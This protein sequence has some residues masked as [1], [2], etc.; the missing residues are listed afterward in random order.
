MSW[1]D[2]FDNASLDASKFG[3]SVA[4][5]G[6]FSE[7]GTLLSFTE[8]AATAN[9][10]IAYIKDPVSGD[11]LIS[12]K[13]NMDGSIDAGQACYLLSFYDGTPAV[14]TWANWNG[15]RKI[16]C[17]I[18]NNSGTYQLQIAYKNSAGTVYYWNQ[19]TKAWSTTA[20]AVIASAANARELIITCIFRNGSFR[21]VIT[22]GS[23]T[24][25]I[26]NTTY[27]ALSGIQ[28][29][30]TLYAFWGDPLT[31]YAYC[32]SL[33]T[34][35]VKFSNS[36]ITW[37]FYNG[38]TDTN[39]YSIGRVLSF[40]GGLT[41]FRDPVTAL[42]SALAGENAVKN[43]SVVEV[44]GTQYM[45]YAARITATSKWRTRLA[46]STD[47]FEINTDQGYAAQ[48]GGAGS[49]NE[50][51][52]IFTTVFYV[53]GQGWFAY[54]T[55]IDA[56]D[57][58]TIGLFTSGDPTATWDADAGNPILSLPDWVDTSI[59][60]QDILYESGTVKL[61][62]N[63]YDSTV[64]RWK[65]GL[66]IITPNEWDT[67]NADARNPISYPPSAVKTTLSAQ[68]NA[69]A[70]SLT[71]TS[72]SGFSVLSPI[73]IGGVLELN[74]IASVIDGTHLALVYPLTATQV[75][76]SVVSQVDYGDPGLPE[77]R[78]AYAF[79]TLIHL[80]KTSSD[81][82][83]SGYLTKSGN[84]FSIDLANTPVITLGDNWDTVSAENMKLVD[85]AITISYALS[86]N[87]LSHVNSLGAGVLSQVHNLTVA[88]LAHSND[89]GAAVLT[90]IHQLIVQELSHANSLGAIT[91]S[92][93][94]TLVIQNLMH[95]LN[96]EGDLVLTENQLLAIQGLTHSHTIGHVGEIPNHYFL[97]VQ[98]LNHTYAIDLVSLRGFFAEH[99]L[100][101]LF[102][103]D[104]IEDIRPSASVTKSVKG[105]F[106][107]EMILDSGLK[108][109]SVSDDKSQSFLQDK[110]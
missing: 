70:T 53:T 51:G 74:R 92:E 103:Q 105:E 8:G 38:G 44:G 4:G 42:I 1:R 45:F 41:F 7:S 95:A 78:G 22:D 99:G 56:S 58:G 85:T 66:Y 63:G 76:G 19:T 18:N 55:G 106:S 79:A 86:V 35:W 37:A 29:Y 50:K 3:T 28:A 17:F 101:Y 11:M 39:A 54:A 27:V 25:D 62:I 10:G 83:I 2:D 71:V 93:A 31:D 13:I 82:E 69:G 98:D 94:Q 88:N 52:T 59:Y 40:D 89:L 9:A 90:Q 43:P 47:Y 57:I 67:L 73:A 77:I 64:P 110:I 46:T 36:S 65:L 14:N 80:T 48:E 81:L 24:K 20:S 49:W 6:A 15:A 5:D 72:S 26:A 33:K 16:F 97:I 12:Q 87:N 108:Q 30:T 100:S 107:E 61:W 91:L 32:T 102:P 68:A 34:D 96:I 60:A 109:L 23:G 104:L 75:N 21:Y 84:T